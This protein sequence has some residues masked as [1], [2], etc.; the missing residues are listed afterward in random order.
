MSYHI[1]LVRCRGFSIAAKNQDAA[2]SALN[3]IVQFSEQGKGWNGE[4]RCFSGLDV[5][6]AQKADDLPALLSAWGYIAEVAKSGDIV[7]LSFPR[8]TIGDDRWMFWALAPFVDANHGVQIVFKG[9]DG[10]YFVY[11][12]QSG[13]VFVMV[14]P[15][16]IEA[17]ASRIGVQRHD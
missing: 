9:E 14:N 12:F 6:Q 4:K 3:R 10:E 5:E 8:S 7:G 16:T 13:M 2:F 11:S 1:E 15:M 17:M